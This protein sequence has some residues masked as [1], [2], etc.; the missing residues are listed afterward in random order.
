VPDYVRLASGCIPSSAPKRRPT[1]DL[2]QRCNDDS[3]DERACIIV[4]ALRRCIH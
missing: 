4:R 2:M 1:M 3:S